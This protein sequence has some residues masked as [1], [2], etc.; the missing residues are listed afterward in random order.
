ML[1][2]FQNLGPARLGAMGVVAA[3]LIAFFGFITL[4]VTAPVLVPLYTELTFEDSSEVI[5]Q[6]EGQNIPFELRNDGTTIL[7]PQERVLRLRMDLAE[8]GLPTGGSVGYEIFD[9]SSTLGA[10]S[11]VQNV[12]QL[13]ALEGELSRTISSI[14]QVAAARVHLVLPERELFQQNQREATASIVLRVRGTL[15][16]GQIR[17]IQHLAA[18]AVDGLAASRVSIVD[19]M[20]QL[21]ANGGA[22]NDEAMMAASLDERAIG[23]EN[24]I[25]TQVENILTEV[26]GPGRARVSVAVE[27]NHNRISETSEVFDPDGQVVRSTQTREETGSTSDTTAGEVTVGNQLPGA[28]PGA[29]PGG[30]QEARETAEEIVNFE[31]SSTSRTEI[32]EAGRLQRLSV[33]VLVDGVYAQDAEGAPSYTPR[34]AEELEQIAALVRSAVGFD[35][36]RGDVVEVVNLQFAARPDLAIDDNAGLFNFTQDDI[37]RAVELAVIALLTL[38]VLFFVIRPLLSRVFAADEPAEALPAGGPN[39]EGVVIG[40]NGEVVESPMPGVPQIALENTTTKALENAIALGAVQ[41]HSLEQIGELIKERPNDA[42]GVVRAWMLTPAE[43][44]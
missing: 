4:R 29:G 11:F 25:R 18:S 39:A 5:R 17:A 34:S 3:L 40:P 38:I 27:L 33:A 42:I 28:E 35:Q 14:N 36:T 9:Q 43:Q 30:I 24:R 16:Q 10:T 7:V 44:K 8:Q 31:I 2:F 37:F 20:G 12:N 32:V 23:M 13:R 6:L 21:L 22:E 26:V 1:A 41:K 19:E 15:D